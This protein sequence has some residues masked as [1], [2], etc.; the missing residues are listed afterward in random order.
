MALLGVEWPA[1]CPQCDGKTTISLYR[2]CD[3]LGERYGA[4]LAVLECRSRFERSDR[5]FRKLCTFLRGG[6]VDEGGRKAS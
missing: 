3:E 2:L 5:V 6:A 1:I 4:L